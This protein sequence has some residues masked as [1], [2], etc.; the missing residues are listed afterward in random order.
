MTRFTYV[1]IKNS[2]TYKNEISLRLFPLELKNHQSFFHDVYCLCGTL[3]GQI[4]LINTNLLSKLFVCTGNTKAEFSR[5][6]THFL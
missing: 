2:L 6:V 3:Y 5:Y 1:F 4:F